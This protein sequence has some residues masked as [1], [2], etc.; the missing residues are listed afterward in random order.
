MNPLPT[1]Y[2]ESS[3]SSN[4]HGHSIS[5]TASSHNISRTFIEG[6]RSVEN[7]TNSL[8]TINIEQNESLQIQAWLSPLKP[9]SRHL[10]VKNQRLH[11][12]G[13]WVLGRSEFKSWSKGQ[14][15]AASP[16]LLCYGGPGVGKT[17]IRYVSILQKP[18]A[19]LTSDKIS[20]L[21]IDTLHDQARGRN[22]AVLCFYCDFQTQKEQSAVNMIGDLLRQANWEAAGTQPEIQIAFKE[23]KRRGC[24]G[25]KLPDMLQ[26]LVKV[27][28]SIDRVYICVDAVDEL[29]PQDQLEFLGALRQ[30]L[31][32]APNTRLFLTARPHARVELDK[33]L[34][35]G[36]FIIHIVV[37]QGDITKYLRWKMD[38]DEDP[39]LMTENLQKDIMKTILTKTSEM[40]VRVTHYKFGH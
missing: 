28:S 27:I 19:M 10:D 6:N 32:D 4:P 23:S 40:Y 34:T 21:V 29:L 18:C 16:T 26:L 17:Y 8:N 37:D 2:R 31:Q 25:L 13:D 15:D 38:H 14:D 3:S 35:K 36:A 39:D 11:G 7:I 9:H 33:Y 1:G 5:N 20:S 30:I 24:Q 22:I 12:V